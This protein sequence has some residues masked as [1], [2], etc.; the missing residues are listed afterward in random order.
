MAVNSISSNRQRIKSNGQ[1]SSPLHNKK[2]DYMGFIIVNLKDIS[3]LQMMKI[4][5]CEWHNLIRSQIWV[6]V[7]INYLHSS[8]KLIEIP[9]CKVK[10]QWWAIV[11]T[12]DCNQISLAVKITEIHLISIIISTLS[13]KTLRYRVV[14]IEL[15]QLRN[16]Y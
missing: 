3:C 11:W 10:P 5:Y 14:P 15:G 9:W 12:W 1:A 6:K 16:R 7:T 4:K 2:L 8:C 13:S